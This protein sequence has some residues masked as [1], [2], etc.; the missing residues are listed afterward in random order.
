MRLRI[1]KDDTAFDFFKRA[2]LTMGL[3]I[4]L[5]IASLVLVAVNGL[6]FGIDFR[7]GTVITTETPEDVPTGDYREV[8][9]GLNLGDVTVSQ[10]NDPASAVTGDEQHAAMIRI[11]QVGERVQ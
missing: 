5:T 8:L 3:S 2:N 7:G 4:L 10:I 9:N 6:N 11:E 1:F